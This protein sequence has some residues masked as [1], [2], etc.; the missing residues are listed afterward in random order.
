MTVA[1]K[2]VQKEYTVYK[3]QKETREVNLYICSDGTE[4]EEYGEAYF[5][6]QRLND[7]KIALQNRTVIDFEFNQTYI[8]LKSLLASFLEV[9]SIASNVD[10]FWLVNYNQGNKEEMLKFF[11]D[12]Y[13]ENALE[14]QDHGKYFVVLCDDS[15]SFSEYHFVYYELFVA[16]MKRNLQNIQSL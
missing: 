7:K 10:C 8:E 14:K 12:I 5:Y 2:K 15:F 13:F 4:F 3:W 9:E 6:E 11:N 16:F 1:T